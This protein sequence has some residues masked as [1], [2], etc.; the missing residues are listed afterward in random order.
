MSGSM[1]NI[2]ETA[3]E[4]LNSYINEQKESNNKTKFSLLFFDTDFFM[5][6]QNV[7]IE[8]VN[9]VTKKTYYARG[10][11]ALYDAVGKM[12][13]DYID[14]LGSTPERPDK[15]LFVIITDGQ[16]NSST[17][18]TKELIKSMVTLM[19]EEFNTEFLFLAANQDACFEAESMGMSGSNA[20][21][22]DATNDGITVAYASAATATSYY[23]DN[24]DVKENLFK[25]KE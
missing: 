17:Y 13:D 10:G 11:T 8:K 15:T 7:D 1:C 22:Y 24:D 9:K 12:I 3:R 19:R 6:Y 25:V 18:Y 5:P 21:N 16:E 4:G 20:F 23:V 14:Y 2:I